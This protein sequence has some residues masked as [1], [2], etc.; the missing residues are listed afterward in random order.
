[1][2]FHSGKCW[3]DNQ[4]LSKGYSQRNI[5]GIR[6]NGHRESYKLFIGAI[7]EGLVIDHLCGNKACY[8]PSH[9]EAVTQKENVLRGNSFFATRS[10]MTHCF[11]GHEFDESNTLINKNG[12][13]RCRKCNHLKYLKRKNAKKCKD[14]EKLF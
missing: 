10:R 11:R 4:S 7:P 1:M 3:I 14:A 5:K 6:Y 9:L 8:R 12:T 2:K 13:R